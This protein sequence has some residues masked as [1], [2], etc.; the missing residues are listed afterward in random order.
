M[1]HVEVN[2][3][4][5]YLFMYLGV[6]FMVCLNPNIHKVY[7]SHGIISFPIIIFTYLESK[8]IYKCG[9]IEM[10]MKY[11][12]EICNKVIQFKRMYHEIL[13]LKRVV[14]FHFFF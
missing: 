4:K 2:V 5:C 13:Y 6:C 11:I 3:L 8:K 10:G 1:I 9:V 14:Q 12:V 7:V